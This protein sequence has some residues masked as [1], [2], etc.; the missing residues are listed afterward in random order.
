MKKKKEF[1]SPLL[2]HSIPPSS[3]S[4][5]LR[6]FAANTSGEWVKDVR[7][8]ARGKLNLRKVQTAGALILEAKCLEWPLCLSFFESNFY[9]F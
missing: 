9:S 4:L 7:K 3:L 2:F 6:I 8:S 5:H 1:Q